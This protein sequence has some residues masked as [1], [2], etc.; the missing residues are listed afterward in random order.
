MLIPMP[1][2]FDQTPKPGDLVTGIGWTS[3]N[4]RTGKLIGP[5]GVVNRPELVCIETA[6]GDEVWV[7][8]ETVRL[9]Q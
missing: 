6:S 5:G 1:L 9:A 2:L 8:P 4:L 3:G 7:L